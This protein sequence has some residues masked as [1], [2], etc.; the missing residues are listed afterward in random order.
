MGHRFLCSG[1][2]HSSTASVTATRALEISYD[3]FLSEVA[4]FLDP[5]VAALYSEGDWDR[6]RTNVAV[7]LEEVEHRITTDGATS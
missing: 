7:W 5:D 3:N 4:P 6:M 1:G 2:A